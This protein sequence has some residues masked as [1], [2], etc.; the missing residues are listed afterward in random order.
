MSQNQESESPPA[1]VTDE[2][3]KRQTLLLV[4]FKSKGQKLSFAEPSGQPLVDHA[5]TATPSLTE[6]LRFFNQLGIQI[7]LVD[8]PNSDFKVLIDATDT[9]SDTAEFRER[10]RFREKSAIASVCLGLICGIPSPTNRDLMHMKRLIKEADQKKEQLGD[11]EDGADWYSFYRV[12]RSKTT[13]AQQKTLADYLRE[14]FPAE[15]P[16]WKLP[17]TTADILNAITA[18]NKDS[19][20]DKSREVIYKIEQF[21]KDMHRSVA[22]D[23]GTTNDALSRRLEKLSLPMKRGRLSRLTVCTNSRT[24]F[25]RIGVA[26]VLI[27]TIVTGGEQL[28]QSDALAG[29][30]AENF[31]K[32]NN[33]MRFGMTMIGAGTV[34]PRTMN[35]YVE[36]APIANMK[37]LFLEKSVIRILAADH[38]KLLKRLSASANYPFS[39]IDPEYLDLIV[40]S[41]P[42]PVSELGV[43]SEHAIKEHLA[44]VADFPEKIS[45]LRERVPVLVAK[46]DMHSEG[47]LSYPDE[48]DLS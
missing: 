40:T 21:W 8:D 44:E 24:I 32:A 31:L 5:D 35:A 23:A 25:Q 34:D 36:E 10:V 27:K 12:L 1:P 19:L 16:T 4:R 7:R 20:R 17:P 11:N 48:Y 3:V 22:I 14:T 15:D 46:F 13:L 2:S 39:S 18:W 26:N 47:C 42:L 9:Y 43:R 41:S 38:S 29:Y 45:R 33:Q 30:L 37:A 28:G 6:D